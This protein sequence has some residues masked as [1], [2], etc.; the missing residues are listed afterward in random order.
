MRLRINKILAQAGITSRRG[1]DQLVLEGRVSVNG[2]IV[3]E[4]GVLADPAEDVIAV[5]GRPI[6]APEPVRY[7]LL[8]KPAGYVTTLR[9]P[10]GR[11]V[12]TDLLPPGPRVFP[13]GRLDADVEGALIL[14]NDGAL[15]HR[16]LHPRYG[17]PRIYEAEVKGTVA[18]ADLARWRRGVELDDGPAVPVTVEVLERRPATTRVRLAFT[19]GRKHEVKRY[20]EALGHP[21]AR[22][23]RVAFGPVK[24]GRLPLG[25]WRPL[26]REELRALRAAVQG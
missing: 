21:V 7:L 24:L 20:C 14:T 3:R 6:P 11:P 13:V 22:L 19:E 8:N 17:V 18:T 25:A 26:S 12:V 23:R 5:D 16:L 9:D 15:A 10:H 4:P 2:Q 1:A